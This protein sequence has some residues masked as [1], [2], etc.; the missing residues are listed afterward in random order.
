MDNQFKNSLYS[1]LQHEVPYAEILSE[2]LGGMKQVKKND[3]I[4]KRMNG[5]LFVHD[6]NQDVDIDFW[7][8][9]VP[10]NFEIKEQIVRELHSAPYTVQ[11]APP[12]PK[13]YS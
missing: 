10:E 11:C 6:Q 4:F 9:V 2:L 3:L 8:I 5:L 13:N 7:R 12:N 1:F